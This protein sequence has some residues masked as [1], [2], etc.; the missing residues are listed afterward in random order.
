[1][2]L[3]RHQK[4]FVF[5][6][7]AVAAIAIFDIWSMNSGVFGTIENYISGNY[8]PGWWTLFWKIN[9]L[10]LGLLSFSYYWFGRKDKS[11]SSSLFVGSVILWFTGMADILFFW[12]RGIPV[13]S[14]LPWLD[15]GMVG[16]ISSI[17]GFPSVTAASLYI[18]AGLGLIIAY[19]T[20]KILV[21]KF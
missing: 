20:T 21:E 2:R 1:M 14:S 3:T 13:S 10:F 7:I 12:F 6:I 9:I 18:S 19:Y 8:L 17:I 16:K 4:I 15:G 5:S 11:E